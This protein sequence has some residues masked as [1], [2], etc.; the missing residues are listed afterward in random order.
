MQTRRFQFVS[1]F[2]RFGLILCLLIASGSFATAQADET[3]RILF[4]G[5]SLTA[6]YGIDPELAYPNLIQ[7]KIDAAKID[8]AVNVGAVSG[9]T[10]AGGLRRI[11]WMLRQPV[12]IFVLALGG[13]DGLR[14]VDLKAAE[15]NLQAIID[16][17]NTTYPE[18]KVVIAGMRL[19]PSIGQKYSEAFA[20]IFPRLAKANDATLIPFLLEDVGGRIELNLADRIHPNPKGHTIIAQTVWSQIKPLLAAKFK[21]VEYNKTSCDD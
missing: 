2:K 6:G 18:A 19:P 13:N 14:G 8:A 7:E 15:A 1:F 11:D 21:K 20:A 12:D 17:V 10:S 4:F 5:D 16:K 3:Q 9:D